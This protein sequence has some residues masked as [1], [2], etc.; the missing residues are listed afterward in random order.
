MF[1]LLFSLAVIWEWLTVGFRSPDGPSSFSL[2][3]PFLPSLRSS[4]SCGATAGGTRLP[5]SFLYE[6]S[7]KRTWVYF[8]FPPSSS[9]AITQH[10]SPN[11]D[12]HEGCLLVRQSQRGFAIPAL[13]ANSC[14]LVD[15]PPSLFWMVILITLV[16]AAAV[17]FDR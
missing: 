12:R 3:L 1:L 7:T 4:H 8:S 17:L 14:G 6:F 5:T 10:C 13:L 16:S 9:G 15:G 11:H 2:F